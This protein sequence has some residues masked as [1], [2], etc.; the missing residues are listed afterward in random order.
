M[1]TYGFS[2][3]SGDDLVN[4]MVSSYYG[5]PSPAKYSKYAYQA[6]KYGAPV[7]ASALM[8][9]SGKKNISNN[10]MPR[11]RGSVAKKPRY[12]SKPIVK[13]KK[14]TL[15]KQIKDLKKV[16]SSDQA[17]HTHRAAAAEDLLASAGQVAQSFY[18]GSSTPTMETAVA[19]LRYYDPAVP[20]T[21]VTANA[22]TGTYSRVLHFSS[23]N[24]KI[25]VR[26]NYQ[27]PCK[28]RVYLALPKQDTNISPSSYFSDGVTDQVISGAT[29]SPLLFP[30][31]IDVLTEAYKMKL[32]KNTLLEPGKQFTVSHTVK[33]I[34]YNP[35]MVDI[36]Q[37]SYQKKYKNFLWYVRVEGPLAHDT[38]ADQQ[39]LAD[40]GVDIQ[41]LTTYKIIY[42]AGVNLNDYSYAE[43]RDTTFTNGAVVSN[44]PVSDNQSYSKA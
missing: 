39:G 27:I 35:A 1:P 40:C 34:D 25:E 26:N 17:Y 33:A 32:V 19:N 41:Y 11:L 30:T 12:G 44:K 13:A 23:I 37:L 10:K 8:A 4:E 7:I 18:V 38:I 16:V 24:G 6:L 15:K 20:G 43:S 22:A 31:D 9:K 28:V 5:T 14:T 29:T 2:G 42:D 36:H 21:L 3:L